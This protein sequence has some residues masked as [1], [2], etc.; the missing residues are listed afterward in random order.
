MSIRPVTPQEIGSTRE[1]PSPPPSAPARSR[2]ESFLHQAAGRDGKIDPDE[3]RIAAELARLEQMRRVIAPFDPLEG[4]LSPPIPTAGERQAVTAYSAQ[5]PP[6]PPP[7]SESVTGGAAP[8]TPPPV[9]SIDDIIRTASRTYQV[10]ERLI[11]GVIR[12]ESGYRVDAVSPVGAQG[13]MQ[14]MPATARQLGV[15]DPFDPVQNVMAGTRFLRDLLKRYDGDMEKALAAYNWGPGNVDRH[16]M[17]IPSETRQYV[18]KVKSFIG[19][20]T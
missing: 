20:M 19:E 12:A 2:F 16:G 15:S 8:A 3:A 11:R 18:A 13:L 17:R 5:A 7:P 1:I 10:D 4:E 9:G 6:P 14:L